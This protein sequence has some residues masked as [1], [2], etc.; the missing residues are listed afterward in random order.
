[1]QGWFNIQI[2]INV[3]NHM[4]RLREKNPGSSQ[5]MQEK[6]TFNEIQHTFIIKPLINLAIELLNLTMS[7]RNLQLVPVNVERLNI[8]S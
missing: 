8:F 2:S 1:M 3:I 7:M 4:N 6:K 5:L